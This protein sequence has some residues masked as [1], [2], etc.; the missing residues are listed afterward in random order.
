MLL[1]DTCALL[2][3]AGNQPLIPAS[4]LDL[5]KSTDEEFAVSAITAFEITLKYKLK[6]LGLPMVPEKWY[7]SA[8]ET[9]GVKEIAMDSEIAITAAEL[10]FIH[11]DPCDR[12]IIATAIKYNTAIITADRIIPQY[13]NI[14]VIW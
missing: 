5:L 14:K 11:K 10:P 9:H 8:L 6:K 2:M 1:L 12:I 7:Y 4:T 3:L 13:P